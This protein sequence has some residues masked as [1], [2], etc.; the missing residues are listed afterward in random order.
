MLLFPSLTS[1]VRSPS[2]ALFQPFLQK[3]IYVKTKRVRPRYRT[4]QGGDSIPLFQMRHQ[5]RQRILALPHLKLLR[6]YPFH[7]ILCHADRGHFSRIGGSC[8]EEGESLVPSD[9]VDFSIVARQRVHYR[10]GP[11]S[12]SVGSEGDEVV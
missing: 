4:P 9:V 8:H 10:A 11:E 6:S 3:S 1:R 2:P 7:A 5:T 12:W